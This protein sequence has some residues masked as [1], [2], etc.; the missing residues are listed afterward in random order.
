MTEVREPIWAYLRQHC[1]S[2]AAMSADA[3]FSDIV[4]SNVTIRKIVFKADRLQ[5]IVCFRNLSSRGTQ[6]NSTC[7]KDTKGDSGTLLSGNATVEVA[8]AMLSAICFF[9]LVC[10]AIAPYT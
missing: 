3:V 10:F 1:N 8:A 7:D 2:F 6:R 5:M 9:V 4:E